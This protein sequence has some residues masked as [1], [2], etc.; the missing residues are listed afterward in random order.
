MWNNKSDIYLI[1]SEPIN[2]P[3][4]FALQVEKLTLYNKLQNY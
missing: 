2:P 4:N 3:G 1:M